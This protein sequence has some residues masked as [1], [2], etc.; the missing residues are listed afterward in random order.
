VLALGPPLVLLVA[1]CVG[2]QDSVA[3]EAAPPELVERLESH[4]VSGGELRNAVTLSSDDGSRYFISV[5][6]RTKAQVERDTAGDILTFTTEQLDGGGL[7]AVDERAAKQT[8]LRSAEV[9]MR[10][11]A[12]VESRGCVAARR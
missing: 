7:A 8:D 1:A 4:L 9:T 12:A 2:P 5:E 11:E 3:C 6:N 10:E